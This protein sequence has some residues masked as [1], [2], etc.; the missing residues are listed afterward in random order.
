MIQKALSLWCNSPIVPAKAR[1]RHVWIPA[2][3]GM[4]GMSGMN[5][6]VPMP[7]KRAANPIN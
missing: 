4:S 2:F 6:V 7:Q 1:T 5:G 3:A